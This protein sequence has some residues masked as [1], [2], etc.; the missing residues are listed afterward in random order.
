MVDDLRPEP[1]EK[2]TSLPD[3]ISQVAERWRKESDTAVSLQVTGQPIPLN[4]Q[5]DVALLRATQESLANVRKHA[6][7]TAVQITLSYMGDVVILDVQDDGVG[8]QDATIETSES[9]AGGYG[10]EAMRERVEAL[11]GSVELESDEGDGTTLMVSLPVENGVH[12]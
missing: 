12:E 6:K 4:G 3:A 5:M 9:M 1:L 10:L 8:I 11:G 2:T 7:A